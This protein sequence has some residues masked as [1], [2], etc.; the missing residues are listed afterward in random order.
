MEDLD[1]AIKRVIQE[2]AWFGHKKYVQERRMAGKD[3]KVTVELS[4]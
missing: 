3:Y 2:V 4:E 1:K